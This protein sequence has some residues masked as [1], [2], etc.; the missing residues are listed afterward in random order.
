MDFTRAI[1]LTLTIVG[2]VSFALTFLSY[3]QKDMI[4]LR[5]IAVASLVCGL[6]YNGWVQSRMTGED[7]IWLVICWLSVFLLQNILLLVREIRDGLEVALAP[8][9]RA[10]LVN[11]FPKMHSRDWQALIANAEMQTYSKGAVILD[12]GQPTESLKLIVSGHAVEHRGTAIRTCEKGTLWGEL[13]FVMGTDYFNSSPVR[14]TSESE[15]LVVYAWRYDKLE[16]L[17]GKN[18]RM[19]AALQHGFVN[20][21]GLKHGLLWVKAEG[22]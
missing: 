9:S 7:D 18:L 17:L 20:S 8:E 3:A 12:V 6:V 22:Q 21:A 2:H 14:I 11:T 16:K 15:T 4:R 10:L 19:Y 13:T 5:M 1:F